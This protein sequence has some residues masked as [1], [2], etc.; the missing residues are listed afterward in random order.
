MPEMY[1]DTSDVWS[2]TEPVSW[3]HHSAAGPSNEFESTEYWDIQVW[4]GAT[5]T[6]RGARRGGK[7]THGSAGQSWTVNCATDPAAVTPNPDLDW[8]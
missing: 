6:S 1:L 8:C 7:N 5:Y 3:N 2:E 4:A